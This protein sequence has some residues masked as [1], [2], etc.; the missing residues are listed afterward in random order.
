MIGLL[1][2]L[3]WMLYQGGASAP[4][5]VAAD[6]YSYHYSPAENSEFLSLEPFVPTESLPE[7]P[8]WQSQEAEP[9]IVYSPGEE[10][11]FVS[12]PETSEFGGQDD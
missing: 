9:V 11:V 7:P 6:V 12:S 8:P 2:P 4:V 1:L 5:F 10:S 3:R